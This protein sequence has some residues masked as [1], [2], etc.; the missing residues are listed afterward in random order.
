MKKIEKMH[1]KRIEA[2]I[3]E[4]NMRTKILKKDAKTRRI[5]ANK[6]K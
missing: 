5:T 3:K 4:I 1:V 6:I 2:E